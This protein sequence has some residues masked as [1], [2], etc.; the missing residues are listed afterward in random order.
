V[1]EA[2]IVSVGLGLAAIGAVRSTW[3]PWGESMLGSITPLGERGRGRRWGPTV[4][5]FT[6]A[7]TIGGASLGGVL[8]AIGQAA[9]AD[10][11]TGLFALGVMILIGV[12]LDAGLVGSG[13][14]SPRRQV[15]EDWLRRYRGWVYATGFGVQLGLGVVTIVSISSVYLVFVASALSGSAATG[16]LIGGSFGLFRAIPLLATAGVRFPHQLSAVNGA[17]RR[18][19]RPMRSVAVGAETG[20]AA[21]ALAAGMV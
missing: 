6:V 1:P 21:V 15:N 11:R 12:A 3:S 7:S 16:A 9:S 2:V 5:L 13:L 4:T 18:W 10:G 20:L 14:P 19:D 8:G 17:L